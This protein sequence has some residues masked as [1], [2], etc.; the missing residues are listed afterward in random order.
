MCRSKNTPP[1]CGPS[2]RWRGYTIKKNKGNIFT[3]PSLKLVKT[4]VV[5]ILSGAY[6]GIRP[7][8]VDLTFFLSGGA[9][10]L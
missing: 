6:S 9:E 10:E 5:I 7:G 8:G 3:L 1:N 4:Q 2:R